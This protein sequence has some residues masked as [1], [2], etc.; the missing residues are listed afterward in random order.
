MILL[1]PRR[2]HPAARPHA[3]AATPTTAAARHY[4]AMATAI[5]RTPPE[6]RDVY[7]S[8]SG[9]IYERLRER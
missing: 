6:N 1:E 4:P 2:R 8:R 9:H 3:L 7:S 5:V